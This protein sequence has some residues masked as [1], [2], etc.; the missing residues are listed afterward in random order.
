MKKELQLLLGNLTKKC[1]LTKEELI[2]AKIKSLILDVIHHIAII[3]V[4]LV[5]NT[6]NLGD[7]NWYKQLK[8]V[9]DQSGI[10]LTMANSIFDYT[11]EYQ[12]NAQKLV[13]TPLTDKCY[14]TLTQ[15]MKM[16]LG[17]NPYGPAGTGKT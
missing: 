14:L 17:G 16:G 1:H 6:S 11:F 13:Y 9:E 3:D 15:A 10:K 12:G 4:L 8:F 2:L 5:N 7:W